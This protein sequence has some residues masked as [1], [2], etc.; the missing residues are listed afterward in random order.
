MKS[1]VDL[2][3]SIKSIQSKQFLFTR[4]LHFFQRASISDDKQLLEEGRKGLNRITET[5]GIPSR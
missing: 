1:N 4:D 3:M 5:F 2:P